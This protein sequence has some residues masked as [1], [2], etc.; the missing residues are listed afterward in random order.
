MEANIRGWILIIGA[1]VAGYL[2]WVS[3]DADKWSVLILALLFLISGYH[4]STSKHKK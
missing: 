2:A 3:N 4:H 1:L